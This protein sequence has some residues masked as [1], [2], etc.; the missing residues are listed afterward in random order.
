MQGLDALPVAVL[1]S[2][3]GPDPKQ[4]KTSTSRSSAFADGSTTLSCS[5]VHPSI[6]PAPV[7]IPLSWPHTP[8]G[9]L[10]DAT[11]IACPLSALHPFL[12]ARY[13]ALPSSAVGSSLI[14][15]TM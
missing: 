12:R 1:V 2:V 5:G 13:K 14:P 9:I 4:M 7:H 15:G 11:T 10:L 3:C 8:A 6:A